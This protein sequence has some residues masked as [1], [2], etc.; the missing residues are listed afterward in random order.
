MTTL[1]SRIHTES[2]CGFAVS[3]LVNLFV[4]RCHF[5]I[6]FES[7]KILFHPLGPLFG[8]LAAAGGQNFETYGGVDRLKEALTDFAREQVLEDFR[9][10]KPEDVSWGAWQRRQSRQTAKVLAQ[11]EVRRTGDDIV[12]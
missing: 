4:Y 9:V 11:V 2:T 8:P 3:I 6:S 10:E 7:L 12:T 1:R 5:G